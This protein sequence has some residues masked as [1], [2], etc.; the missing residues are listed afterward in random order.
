MV[1]TPVL[2]SGEKTQVFEGCQ[3]SLK[4]ARPEDLIADG[5]DPYDEGSNGTWLESVVQNATCCVVWQWTPS[6]PLTFLGGI[7][8]CP[9]LPSVSKI[10]SHKIPE[11]GLVYPWSKGRYEQPFTNPCSN[12][13]EV[14]KPP[15]LLPFW[16]SVC[17]AKRDTTVF[18]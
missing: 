14:V 4:N 13:L 18:L 9:M 8:L 2:V 3:F 7:V 16:V 6:I 15:G 10:E 17:I 12:R 5:D 1:R 11:T